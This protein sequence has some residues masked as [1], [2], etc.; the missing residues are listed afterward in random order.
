MEKYQMKKLFA[1]EITDEQFKQIVSV[2]QSGSEDCYTKEQLKQIW[3][4]N[5]TNDNFVCI[6]NENIVAHISFN[7]LS[8]KLGGSIYIINLTV[9]PENRR[10]GIA[11]NLINFGIKYYSENNNDKRISLSVDKDNGPAI[12]LYKKL[13][14][15]VVSEDNNQYHMFFN[16]ENFKE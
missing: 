6:E 11:Q 7:P 16:S 2:E 10:K 5:K 4:D 1:D 3:I 15:D 12:N 14:F 8:K 9:A 13:G